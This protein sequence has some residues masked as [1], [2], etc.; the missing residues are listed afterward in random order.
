[1]STH[2][3]HPLLGRY[4]DSAFGPPYSEIVDPPLYMSSLFFVSSTLNYCE[5]YTLLS[6]LRYIVTMFSTFICTK[7]QFSV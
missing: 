4:A 2:Y 3:T 1:M 6:I 7:L 5:V